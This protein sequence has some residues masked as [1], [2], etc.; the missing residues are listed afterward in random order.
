MGWSFLLDDVFLARVD[1]NTRCR[2]LGVVRAAG[3]IEPQVAVNGWLIALD[4]VDDS[5]ALGV[6]LL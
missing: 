2:G 6:S 5:C 4:T 1:V 3:D